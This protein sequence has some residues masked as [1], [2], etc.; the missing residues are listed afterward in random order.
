VAAGAPG[1]LLG[2]P[3]F[4]VHE[5][6]QEAVVWFSG[7]D[8]LW[9]FLFGI[10]A[11][12]LFLWAEKSAANP[13][14]G[15]VWFCRAA[16]VVL[17]ALAM[18]SKESAVILPALFLVAIAPQD[19]SRAAA[20]RSPILRLLP[21][22]A[23]AALAAAS[24]FAAQTSTFRFS[25][26]SFSLRAP[27]WITWPRGFARLLWFWGWPALVLARRRW[28]PLAWMAIGLVPFCFLTYSTEI[29]SRQTYLASAGLALL[30]GLGISRIIPSRK[31]AAA[32][33]VVIVV[34]NVAYLWTKKRSQF[35]LRAEPTE[36]L[37]R[38]A[39]ETRG[40]IWIRC[41]PRN[42]F[43]AQ[44]AVRL[45]AGRPVA[46]I[47]WDAREASEKNAAAFCYQGR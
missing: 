33:L 24:I 38:F 3:L 41:F 12:V 27:F 22:A 30:V 36:Q 46:D 8:E 40:P 35:L 45:G 1:G 47:V 42:G 31:L 11:L 17:L 29:P 16:S 37:I 15:P 4:A 25:D 39:R 7:I 32:I 26:G 21:Y 18:L 10:G 13:R 34:Q 6:H 19:W 43:I 14:R 20:W 44:E 28:A 2:R 23:V 9:Q 5:G